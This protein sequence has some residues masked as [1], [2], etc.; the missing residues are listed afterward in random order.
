MLLTV[1]VFITPQLE[2]ALV[3]FLYL[4]LYLIVYRR[5]QLNHLKKGVMLPDDSSYQVSVCRG[6]ARAAAGGWLQSVLRACGDPLPGS[7]GH[8]V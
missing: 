7:L 5:G 6:L 2:L 4:I 3:G 8:C 1:F